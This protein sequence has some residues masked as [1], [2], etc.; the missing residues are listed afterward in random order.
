VFSPSLTL[1]CEWLFARA[2]TRDQ[3]PDIN[4]FRRA[5]RTATLRIY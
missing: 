5:A 3:Q 2:M 4:E 1:G